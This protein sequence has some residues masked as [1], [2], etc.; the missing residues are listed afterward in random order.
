MPAVAVTLVDGDHCRPRRN[1]RIGAE[2]HRGAQRD[3]DPEGERIGHRRSNVTGAGTA[4]VGIGLALDVAN[5]V[6]TATTARGRSRRRARSRSRH[7]EP[8]RA[9]RPPAPRPGRTGERGDRIGNRRRRG[10]R[11][12]SR[13]AG[14]DPARQRGRDERCQRRY[15]IRV[16]HDAERVDV[17]RQGQ[18]GGGRRHRGREHVIAGDDR[19][20]GI[21]LTS[22]GLVTLVLVGEHGCVDDSRRD[23]LPGRGATIGAAVAMTLA[24]VTNR[25]ALPA[26]DTVAAKSLT[27]SATETVNGADLRSTYGA[28]ATSGAAAARSR[29]P[30]P[31]GC[32]RQ[33]DDDRGDRRHRGPHRRRR[34]PHGVL[35]REQHRHG[36]AVGG[37]GHSTTNVGV[38][39]SVALAIVTDT[40]TASLGDGA[41][42]PG[43]RTHP[44]RPRRRMPSRPK[45][46]WAPPGARS[47]S[48]P[49]SRSRCRPSRPRPASER[50][51]RRA[52]ELPAVHGRGD[53]E[54]VGGPRRPVP[55]RRRIDGRRRHRPRADDRKR[56]GQ[57]DD[58]PVDHGGAA[59]A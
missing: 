38:G 5:H 12:R 35:Q 21:T 27:I 46:R 20:P 2:P 22:G 37:R 45:R 33:P 10:S 29:S 50:G 25:A 56:H 31:S 8:A 24:N 28:Q 52:A 11:R 57:R 43:R 53:A 1:R 30:V 36:G 18:C 16:D 40:T 9:P 3:G 14:E 59:S 32:D 34:D 19:E 6:V 39:A 23:G 58:R 44:S 7:P 26:G 17:R 15:V 48:L 41:A 4:G 49:P 42:V 47:T 55:C 54:C 13:P 51:R